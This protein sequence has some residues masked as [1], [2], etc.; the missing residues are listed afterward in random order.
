MFVVHPE[1]HMKGKGGLEGDDHTPV[2]QGE[3]EENG[4]GQAHDRIL[5]LAPASD[6]NVIHDE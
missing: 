5:F 2:M 3:R 4:R 1:I 6:Q